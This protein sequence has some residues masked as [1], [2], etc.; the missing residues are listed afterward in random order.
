M[1]QVPYR[2]RCCSRFAFLWACVVGVTMGLASQAQAVLHTWTGASSTSW[3]NTSN[4]S[5]SNIPATFPGVNDDVRIT[6]FSPTLWPILTSN[7]TVRSVAVQGKDASSTGQLEI[8]FAQL[9]VTDDFLIGKSG[10]GRGSVNLQQSGSKLLV[11]N[12]QIVLES[13]SFVTNSGTID[14]DNSQ[15]LI[16]RG[17]YTQNA[18]GSQLRASVV[19][20]QGGSSSS[21]LHGAGT[22]GITTSLTIN[23]GSSSYAL[24]GSGT[25]SVPTINI[26]G[27]GGGSMLLLGNAQITQATSINVRTDGLFDI[28]K[29]FD[30]DGTLT[31]SSNGIVKTKDGA[32]TKTLTMSG[33][34]GLLRGTGTV[35]GN[36]LNKGE[37]DPGSSAGVVGS[38]TLMNDYEQ[39]SLGDL[40]IDI[41]GTSSSLYDNLDVTGDV[42]LGG[43][44]TAQLPS[45]FTPVEGD[46]FDIISFDGSRTGT[47]GTVT[48]PIL[49]SGISMALVYDT[50][51]VSL[52]A[53]LDGD[54]NLDGFVGITDLNIVLSNWNLNVAENVW[55]AGDPS[56]DGFVGIDDLNIVLGNW[57]AGTPPA[58]SITV[59][60]PA[61]ILW[62]CSGALSLLING[63]LT[64]SRLN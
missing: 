14:Q 49:T 18:S 12:G 57:N 58:A 40:F 29:D 61:G 54:L 44:L 34:N 33:L 8:A 30:F 45:L 46:S 35:E 64:R 28:R 1:W 10:A 48:L 37:V 31:L 62:L 11:T 50:N 17:G 19:Q 3:T 56:S 5:S 22:V 21:F 42:T 4:W 55:L 32:T 36:L 47:F 23:G 25:L 63:G 41:R 39:S 51:A 26:G 6:T 53:G 27:F 16:I 60:E 24:Q 59:P 43:T 7:R 2:L 20:V 13:G 38:L 9:T 52:A 15:P